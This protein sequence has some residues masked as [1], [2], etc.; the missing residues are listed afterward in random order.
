MFV[1][2]CERIRILLNEIL[3]R[4]PDAGQMRL[5]AIIY[6]PLIAQELWKSIVIG[7][8]DRNAVRSGRMHNLH[9]LA[10]AR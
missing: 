6:G 8:Q 7:L 2:I 3:E 9:Y 5:D 1:R 10:E 4:I